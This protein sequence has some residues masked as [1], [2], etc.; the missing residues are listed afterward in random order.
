MKRKVVHAGLLT[1]LDNKKKKKKDNV[2]WPTGL[3]LFLL[4]SS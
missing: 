2:D 3:L 1:G 4:L